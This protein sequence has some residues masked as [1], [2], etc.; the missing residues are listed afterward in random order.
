M[1]GDASHGLG[2]EQVTILIAAGMA[3]TILALGVVFG[4]FFTERR[5]HDRLEDLESRN[6]AGPA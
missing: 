6:R 3:M 1:I 2:I 5:L 4:G